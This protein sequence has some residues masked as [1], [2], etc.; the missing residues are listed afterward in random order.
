MSFPDSS[1]W[2]PS[3]VLVKQ[4]AQPAVAQNGTFTV[5]G[6][7]VLQVYEA[8]ATDGAD[9]VPIMTANNAPSGVASADTEYSAVYAAWKAF[10]KNTA[11][12]W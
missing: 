6:F 8:Y 4:V 5:T 10:D 9:A 11:T 3:G 12:C 2:R 7:S 1:S